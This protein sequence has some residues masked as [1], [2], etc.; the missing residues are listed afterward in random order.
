MCS[1]RTGTAGQGPEIPGHEG[2]IKMHR[3]TLEP[4]SQGQNSL[5]NKIDALTSAGSSHLL[6]ISGGSPPSTHGAQHLRRPRQTGGNYERTTEDIVES[7]SRREEYSLIKGSDYV[8]YWG[9]FSVEK[10]N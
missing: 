9:H 5:E 7:S 10:D 4:G 6:L 3:R 8:A 2:L 1:L